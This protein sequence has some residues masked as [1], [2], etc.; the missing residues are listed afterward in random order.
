MKADLA[1]RVMDERDAMVLC[2][3]EDFFRDVSIA[4]DIPVEKVEAIYLASLDLQAAQY[5][6]ERVT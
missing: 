6:M 3:I 5:A 4:Y 2:D 1:Q